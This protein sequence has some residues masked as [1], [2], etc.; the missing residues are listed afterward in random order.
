MNFPY[1]KAEFFM[2]IFTISFLRRDKKQCLF[3]ESSSRYKFQ[4]FSQYLACIIFFGWVI[5]KKNTLH[6]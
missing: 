6:R 4:F 3:Q 1:K 2:S 5:F